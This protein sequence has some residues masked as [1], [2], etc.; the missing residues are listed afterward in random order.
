MSFIQGCP[1]HCIYLYL[2]DVHEIRSVLLVLP[3]EYIYND[4]INWMGVASKAKAVLSGTSCPSSC[5][6]P[7]V[8]YRKRQHPDIHYGINLCSTV[9]SIVYTCSDTILRTY[10]KQ[11]ERETG[12]RERDE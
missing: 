9:N 10:K 3:I 1:L 4:I 7:L 6:Q 8:S 2:F 11:E 12:T 5:D